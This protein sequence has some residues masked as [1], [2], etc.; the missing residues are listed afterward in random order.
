MEAGDPRRSPSRLHLRLARARPSRGRGRREQREDRRRLLDAAVLRTSSAPPVPARGPA[1]EWGGAASRGGAARLA[2]LHEQGGCSPAVR[3]RPPR[4]PGPARHG[5]G[6]VAA[7]CSAPRELEWEGEGG[8]REGEGGRR[9]RRRHDPPW[10]A[11]RETARAQS[12]LPGAGQ[13]RAARGSGR[14]RGASAP[15][16][17]AAREEEEDWGGAAREEGRGRGGAE[18]RPEEGG[19]ARPWPARGGSR[20]AHGQ[21]AG[22]EPISGAAAARRCGSRGDER[23]GEN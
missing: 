11:A 12:A 3:A 2:A 21:G 17:S 14:R 19:G 20:S 5:A 18:L 16:A 15:R 8:R 7:P 10:P 4:V 23:M 22:R 1:R 13:R 9:G 6:A